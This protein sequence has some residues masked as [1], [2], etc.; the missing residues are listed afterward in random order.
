LRYRPPATRNIFFKIN[1]E[2]TL[3]VS[4][5]FHFVFLAWI[6]PDFYTCKNSY[7]KDGKEKT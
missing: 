7:L 4:T 1:M 6:I 3:L 5:N 2:K